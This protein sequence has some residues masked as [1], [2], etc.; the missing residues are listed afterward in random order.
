MNN[1]LLVYGREDSDWTLWLVV[2]EIELKKNPS[3][4]GPSMTPEIL[5]RIQ[6]QAGE[7]P[8]PEMLFGPF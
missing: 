8:T 6:I 4:I 7:E 2:P 5:Q 1:T 3:L